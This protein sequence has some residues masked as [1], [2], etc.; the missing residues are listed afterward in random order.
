MKKPRSDFRV[1]GIA[2]AVILAQEVGQEWRYVLLWR[3]A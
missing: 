2:L 1:V 3:G